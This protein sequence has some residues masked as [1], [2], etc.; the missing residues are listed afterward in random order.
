[1]TLCVSYAFDAIKVICEGLEA[2]KDVAGKSPRNDLLNVRDPEVKKAVD[3][4]LK[5]DIVKC[6]NMR[7]GK[8]PQSN[9]IYAIYDR[10]EAEIKE[11][12]PTAK[13]PDIKS[14]VKELMSKIMYE[15]ARADSTRIDGR[16]F[17]EVR[18]IR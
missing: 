2:F 4:L 17:D 5:D 18:P 11:M 9:E 7:E 12:I 8:I 1:M 13:T 14:S 16:Q 6:F 10:G 3:A 15:I